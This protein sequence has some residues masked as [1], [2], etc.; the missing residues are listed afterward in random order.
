MSKCKGSCKA[1]PLK[2]I[3]KEIDKENFHGGG[4]TLR[5]HRGYQE[6]VRRVK[7]LGL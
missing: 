7:E 4:G 3:L 1:C 5:Y 2:N 6:L